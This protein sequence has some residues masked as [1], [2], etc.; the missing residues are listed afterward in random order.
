V[1][2]VDLGCR[3]DG[4][5]CGEALLEGLA[6]AVSIYEG[7][8]MKMRNGESSEKYLTIRH[9]GNAPARV[10]SVIIFER[11]ADQSMSGEAEAERER[12]QVLEAL[13]NMFANILRKPFSDLR[14]AKRCLLEKYMSTAGLNESF[15]IKTYINFFK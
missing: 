10:S 12:T 7:K 5:R 8:K 15:A 4:L 6:R 14:L 11:T 2:P 3:P 1:R 13:A 9:N